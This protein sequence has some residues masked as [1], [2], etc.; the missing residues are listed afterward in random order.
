MVGVRRA[1]AGNLP[2]GLGEHRGVPAVRVGD[3]A[4]LLESCGTGRRWVGV[5]LDGRKLALDHLA[6][7]ID[8]HHLRRLK[9]VVGHAAGL[10]DHQ[11]P[12]GDRCR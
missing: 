4:D 11:P 7:Q 2:P 9:L 6:L 8:D 5:S 10:D 1:Q 3:A 12:L